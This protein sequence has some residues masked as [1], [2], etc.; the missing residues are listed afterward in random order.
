[1][2]VL[3]ARPLKVDTFHWKNDVSPNW[4]VDFLWEKDTS[5]KNMEIEWDFVDK[6]YN[7]NGKPWKYSRIC[8]EILKDFFIFHFFLFFFSIFHFAFFHFHFFHFFLFSFFFIVFFFF[9]F[10]V[11]RADAKTGQKLWRSSCCKKDD[12]SFVKIGFLG[13]G[14]REGDGRVRTGPFEGDP[15]FMFFIIFSFFHFLLFLRT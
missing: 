7:N 14:G 3:V 11:A 12:F 9:F 2:C 5:R 10:P 1:M 15:A 4:V 8:M 6:R 13:L